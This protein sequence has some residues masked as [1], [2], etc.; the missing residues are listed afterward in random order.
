MGFPPCAP[1]PAPAPAPKRLAKG[2]ACGVDCVFGD[3]VLSDVGCAAGVVVPGVE[4]ATEPGLPPKRAAKGF[5]PL[6]EPNIPPM[7]PI[8]AKGFCGWFCCDGVCVFGGCSVVSVAP[9]AGNEGALP[10]IVRCI[11]I[12]MRMKSGLVRV[13]RISGLSN[14]AW[15]MGLLRSMGLLRIMLITS[16]LFMASFICWAK[17][18]FS[19]R[20]RS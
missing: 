7:L 20:R 8:A 14:M 16:G 5:A 2:L 3:V 19:K 12:C 1:A 11:C 15:A 10:P 4:P 17:L 18:G 6:G 9:G 13:R